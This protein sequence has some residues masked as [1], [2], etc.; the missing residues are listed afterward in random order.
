MKVDIP[1]SGRDATLQAE[2]ML[3]NYI[4]IDEQRLDS[5]AQQIRTQKRERVKLGKKLNLSI[6]GLGVELS[7]EDTWRELS[8][9]EKI[10]SLIEFLERENV[11]D[12]SRPLRAEG[13]EFLGVPSGRS[14]VLETMAARKVIIPEPHLSSFPGIKHLAVWV[15]DPDP[16]LFS[17][18]DDP[19]KNKGT[20]VFLTEAYLDD[21]R[22][23]IY[24]GC[25][26]LQAIVNAVE[27]KPMNSPVRGEPLGRGS[28]AHPIEKL[29]SIGA[30]VGDLRNIRS[31]Y[32]KRCLTNEQCYTLN[33][34]PRRVNDLL[35]YPIFIEDV[36]F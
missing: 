7:E 15:S 18:E 3:R 33:G 2:D 11:L 28:C 36:T 34:E 21:K 22:G 19:W 31:L 30:L 32:V 25:S 9:H 27:G 10:E 12:T 24:S 8:A 14:F 6:T 20:F 4:Y 16:T 13:E 35:G 29:Q 5:F 1:S 23:Y 26:A 17:R